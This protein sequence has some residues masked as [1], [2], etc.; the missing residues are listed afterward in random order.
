MIVVIQICSP[1]W[2]GLSKGHF[3]HKTKS[4]WP[5]LH[6]KH[7][8]WWKRQ[9]WSKFSSH[10]AWG[11]NRVSECKMDVKVYMDSYMALN[12]SC[13]MLTWTIFKNR[14]L[15]IGLT[16]NQGDHGTLKAHKRWF[17]LF[18]HVWGLTW[19]EMHWNSIWLSAWSCMAPHYTWGS[20][21]TLHDFG[22][23]L[24]QP[25]NTFFWALTISW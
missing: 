6:F 22:G 7:T 4:P 17:V 5:S 23:V 1:N 8:H 10:C 13:F 3:T 12:G 19:I 15:E 25:L 11:T 16:Q 24:G 9:S 18:Y 21:T 2:E 20:V 14:L